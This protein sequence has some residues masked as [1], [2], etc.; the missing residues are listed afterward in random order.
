MN[1][2]IKTT[3]I[4]TKTL[5]KVTL[6]LT[7]LFDI[8]VI[9]I[10]AFIVKNTSFSMPWLY[11]SIANDYSH[12][13][14]YFFRSS[15]S[16]CFPSKNSFIFGERF[17][18][19]DESQFCSTFSFRSTIMSDPQSF[20][21]SWYT[22]ILPLLN[23]MDHFLTEAAFFPTNVFDLPINFNKPNILCIQK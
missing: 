18:S 12:E 17:L 2:S 16:K 14:A 15:F 1:N 22:F 20:R 13:V 4:Q 11:S 8:V 21:F 19:K 6:D 9:V 5:F 3:N 23:M 10:Q 7:L